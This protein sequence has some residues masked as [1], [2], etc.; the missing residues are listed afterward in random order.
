MQ[1]YSKLIDQTFHYPTPEFR[2]QDNRLFFHEVDLMDIIEK[3]GTPLKLTYLPK[4]G[5]QIKKANLE[6]DF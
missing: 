3:Y 6:I 2:T 5:N 4:I 1:S